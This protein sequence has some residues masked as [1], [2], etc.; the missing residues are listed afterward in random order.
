MIEDVDD[1]GVD[2]EGNT[3]QDTTT[4]GFNVCVQAGDTFPDGSCL[5]Y[6]DVD[7]YTIH[8]LSTAWRGDNIVVRFGVTNVF[9]D[10]P[11][12]TNN[13]QLF[14]PDLNGSGVGGVG[15]D[16]RGRTYFVNVTM[17]L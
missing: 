5:Q 2:D 17:G 14:D 4:S 15:Y 3:N 16:L 6:D 13:N 11:P 8:D 10:A 12:I 1:L 7:S 9:D